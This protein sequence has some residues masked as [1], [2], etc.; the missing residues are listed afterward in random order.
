MLGVQLAASV[1]C[2]NIPDDLLF[3]A[4]RYSQYKARTFQTFS[5]EWELSEAL[6]NYV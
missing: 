1:L 3:D 4:C 5:N 2:A 6:V